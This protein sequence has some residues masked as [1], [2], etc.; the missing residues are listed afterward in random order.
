MQMF[1][2]SLMVAHLD[3][4]AFIISGLGFRQTHKPLIISSRCGHG[5]KI[6]LQKLLLRFR[7]SVKSETFG[8]CFLSMR[9]LWPQ[10]F[11]IEFPSLEKLKVA[12]FIFLDAPRAPFVNIHFSPAWTA[13][14]LILPSILIV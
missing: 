5:T 10:T 2:Y 11:C 7:L 14:F 9:R 3:F 13:T 1:L 4:F 8:R 6:L 12:N